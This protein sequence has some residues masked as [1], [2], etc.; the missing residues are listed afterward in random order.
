[1]K[2]IL[3]DASY[4]SNIQ[5]VVIKN[6]KLE[7]LEYS[8][9][10]KKMI[11][12]NIY[13]AKVTRVEPSLQ[14]AFIDYGEEK[15]GFISFAEIHSSY[16][17]IPTKYRKGPEE[18]S[19][20]IDDSVE[21]MQELHDLKSTNQNKKEE[22]DEQ[23]INESTQIEGAFEEDIDEDL[24]SAEEGYLAQVKQQNVEKYKI[25]EV[26]KRNQIFLVQVVKE[27]RGSKGAAFTT[28]I[29]LA[30]RYCVIMPSSGSKG[31]VSKKITDIKERQRLKAIVNTISESNSTGVI[32]RTVGQNISEVGI[33]QDYNYL[34]KLWNEIREKTLVSTAPAF[35]YAEDDIL[36]KIV[37]DLYDNNTNEILI[38][39]EEGYQEL[40]KIA[41]KMSSNED[42][43]IKQ[44][45]DKAPVFSKFKIDEQIANLYNPVVYTDSGAYIV[46]NHTEALI[47]ID[48]NSGK[49]TSERN[50]E[51]MAVKT[52]LEAAK[53]IAR[54]IKLRDLSGII[55]IDFIDMLENKNK[56]LV[57]RTLREILNHDRAKLQMGY[58]SNLGLVEIS[59]QRL[60]A[61]FLESNTVVCSQCCGKGVVRSNDTNVVMIFRTLEGEISKGNFSEL[62]IYAAPATTLYI[63]NNKREEL[64]LIEKKHNV[65]LYFYQD[66]KMSSDGFAI[67]TVEKPAKFKDEKVNAPHHQDNSNS[68]VNKEMVRKENNKRSTTTNKPKSSSRYKS[69][70]SS[71]DFKN[72]KDSIEEKPKKKKSLVKNIIE[73]FT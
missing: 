43:V 47:A 36:K 10:S 24:T 72:N 64:K 46:I 45:V 17:D 73:K 30:G 19:K 29:S 60:K 51:E 54:Q 3:V 58:I 26:I 40:K 9:S 31:G 61:N 66:S 2:K 18:H 41:N 7:E 70:S 28:Y 4:S 37:R 27:E 13:L 15:Q 63:L 52:N 22:I 71:V 12:G 32:I 55:V 44:Y 42:I 33:Q 56:R 49:S 35:V 67:E 53:E 14:A 59:R 48:V 39:G 62:N 20:S 68:L 23:S 25:Q 11:K 5:A 21:S 16:Y 1:M 6:G 65:N 34:V 38:E 8:S 69:K 50:I 57:E